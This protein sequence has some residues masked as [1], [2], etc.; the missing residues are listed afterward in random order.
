MMKKQ[1]KYMQKLYLFEPSYSLLH[2]NS[3]QWGIS[4]FNTLLQAWNQI[5][6]IFWV[7]LLNLDSLNFKLL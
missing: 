2:K 1:V 5:K 4:L 7:V 3:I 6:V